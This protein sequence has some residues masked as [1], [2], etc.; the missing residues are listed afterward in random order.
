[1]I[2]SL[3]KTPFQTVKIIIIITLKSMININLLMVGFI[4]DKLIPS[5]IFV[6]VVFSIFLM[7]MS[8]IMEDGIKGFFMGLVFLIIKSVQIA[9]Y[10]PIIKILR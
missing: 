1:M 8:A 6:E 4:K 5:A 9:I 3:K 10:Q 2:K 7:E